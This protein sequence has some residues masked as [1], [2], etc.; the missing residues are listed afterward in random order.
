MSSAFEGLFE[1]L[2]QVPREVEGQCFGPAARF[3]VFAAATKGTCGMKLGVEKSDPSFH[4]FA[5]D[6]NEA[7]EFGGIMHCPLRFGSRGDG[8]AVCFEFL[9]HV[10][11]RPIRIVSDQVTA[12]LRAQ[13]TVQTLDVVPVA[14][15]MRQERHAA[16]R[17]KNQMLPHA[18]IVA[19]QRGTVAVA[20]QAAHALFAAR[21]HGPANIYRMGVD[22]IK[23]GR[24]SP[25][26]SQSAWHS[27][28]SK[29]V[30]RARRSA[31][32][33]RDKRRGKSSR[34]V[35]FHSSHWWNA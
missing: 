28:C 2:I 9:P 4:A 11:A 15:H 12:K 24:P 21:S 6:A 31:K 25:A 34:M 16:S 35:G 3:E 17:C 23:R 29:G 14:W 8:N 18:V 33:C 19:I 26:N 27:C 30:S 32:F 10:G 1:F 7:L 5:V 22:N 20:D 13:Q